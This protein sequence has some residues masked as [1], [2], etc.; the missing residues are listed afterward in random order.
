M[1]ISTLS[2]TAPAPAR[3]RFS[4]ESLRGFPNWSFA[5]GLGFVGFL[6][7]FVANWNPSLWGDE[8]ASVLSAERP[9]PSLFRML[10]NVDAVHGTYY[11][12]LHF[13]IDLFGASPLAIRFPSAIAA[14]FVVAG[15]FVVGTQ[16]ASRRLG[17]VAGLLCATLP[18]LVSIG[19]EARSYA[20]STAIGVWLTIL[21]VHLIQRRVTGRLAWLGYAA[22]VALGL[23]F[24][25]YLV[26]L[27]A[28]H[29]VFVVVRGGGIRRRW[30][31][32]TVLGVVAALPVA[33]YGYQERAQIAFLAHRN[34]ATFGFITGDQWFGAGSHLMAIAAWTLVAIAIAGVVVATRRRHRISSTAL[35]ALTWMALPTIL[36]LGISIVSPSYNLRYLAQS[37]PGVALVLAMG[38]LA[39]R[40]RWLV[41]GATVAALTIAVPFDVGERTSFAYDNSDWSSVAA[42]VQTVAQPGDAV[43]FDDT[44]RPSRLPRLALRTYP[45]AFAGL[46]DVELE[47]PYDQTSGLWDATLPLDEVAP[48]LATVDRVLLFEIEGSTDHSS[49]MDLDTLAD[50]G[51]T[52][53]TTHLVHRTVVYTLTRGTS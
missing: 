44:V 27:I 17:L 1:A 5:I 16:L 34:Y 15:V 52:L 51:F 43:I 46:D 9:L 8:A 39:L 19:G 32:A 22:G 25:L 33:W 3:R 31:Q 49:H 30:L 14:G 4:L 26:L 13:W 38:I 23:Y 53:H 41:V 2:R 6:V 28:V 7:S 12:F 20:I 24:F 50:L 10:G 40:A 47:T 37:L 36:L 18:R 42:Y 45:A 29:A 48:R 11:L 35:L 21:L